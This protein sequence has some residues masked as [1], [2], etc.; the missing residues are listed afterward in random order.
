MHLRQRKIPVE[1]VRDVRCGISAFRM[2]DGVFGKILSRNRRRFCGT[3]VLLTEA[4][5]SRESRMQFTKCSPIDGQMADSNGVV[6][7]LIGGSDGIIGLCNENVVAKRV[8]CI[9]PIVEGYSQP[10]AFP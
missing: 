10:L 9:V 6:E 3:A 7:I 4:A 5:S 2:S 8:S 1:S